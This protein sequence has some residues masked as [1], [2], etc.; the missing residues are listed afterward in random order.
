MPA[1]AGP[2]NL[3]TVVVRAAVALNTSTGQLTITTGKLPSILEGVPLRLKTVKVEI[4]KAN[5]LDNPTN[6][7]ASQ[8]TGS[9][10]STARKKGRS[11][12]AT[13][14]TGCDSLAFSPT[15][16]ATPSTTKHDSPTGL[17]LGLKIPASSA[18][19][20]G[21]VITLPAGMSINPAGAV[22]P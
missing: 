20:K 11:R 1:I 21:A 12:A 5:F 4:S 9:S 6:C 19:L 8:I 2:Y 17:E 3:G 7:E 16:S 15:I 14:M 10:T 22:G 13:Q 18:A